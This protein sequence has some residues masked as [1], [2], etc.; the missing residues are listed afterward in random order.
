MTDHRRRPPQRSPVP[1]PAALVTPLIVA[2]TFFMEAVDAN[3][4][5]TALPALARDLRSDPIALKI[6]I[7]SYVVGLGVFIPV[8]GWLADRFGSLT[9]FRMVNGF[10][11]AMYGTFLLVTT[12]WNIWC[13]ALGGFFWALR[14]TT[15]NS[16]MYADTRIAMW[17]VPPVSE[18]SCSRCHW[19]SGSRSA[20]SYCRYR[21]DST[22]TCTPC[23]S[24]SGWA[25]FS[26]AYSRSARSHLPG[27]YRRMPVL[28]CLAT[29]QVGNHIDR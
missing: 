2:C 19:D 28:N 14:F 26:P 24:I 9:V 22:A 13:A 10:F 27:D 23:R 8:C 5:V 21:A 17:A 18:T 4:I 12:L 16:L 29:E 6:A 25:F 1:P 15:L 7:T 11:V 20:G 3:I